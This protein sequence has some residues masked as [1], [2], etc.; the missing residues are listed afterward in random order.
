MIVRDKFYSPFSGSRS[1]PVQI[2]FKLSF[3]TVQAAWQ[4]LF[5][6]P[7]RH[8]PRHVDRL[9]FLTLQAGRVCRFLSFWRPSKCPNWPPLTPTDIGSRSPREQVWKPVPVCW[10]PSGLLACSL[11]RVAWQTCSW[12]RRLRLR[13]ADAA[14]ILAPRVQGPGASAHL[15][16]LMATSCVPAMSL[17]LGHWGNCKTLS[18]VAKPPFLAFEQPQ[19]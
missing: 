17:V 14:G 11:Q 19:R 1:I 2:E 9:L 12:R 3:V 13:A 8:F 16:V 18:P 10:S 4:P 5:P 7:N 15:W 6:G